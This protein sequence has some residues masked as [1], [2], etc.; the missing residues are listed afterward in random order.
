M[1]PFATH[2]PIQQKI[3][4]SINC[5][6]ILTQHESYPQSRDTWIDV[7]WIQRH[8]FSYHRQRANRK[9]FSFTL[10]VFLHQES[11][12]STV[13]SAPARIIEEHK[14]QTIF[15]TISWIEQHINLRLQTTVQAAFHFQCP[16]P[17]RPNQINFGCNIAKRPRWRPWWDLK[18]VS[19]WIRGKLCDF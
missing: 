12:K 8:W 19:A 11:H 6:S 15:L 13:L 16:L 18:T 2:K 3:F 7:F 5:R 14:R 10:E 9:M 4:I 1:P 17:L